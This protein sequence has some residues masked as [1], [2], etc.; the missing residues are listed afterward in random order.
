MFYTYCKNL[1][2]FVPSV[3]YTPD[4]EFFWDTLYTYDYIRLVMYVSNKCQNVFPFIIFNQ[5]Y[6][7]CQ[8]NGIRVVLQKKQMFADLK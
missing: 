2:K 3:L 4:A 6:A 7:G 1:T 8:K 5:I